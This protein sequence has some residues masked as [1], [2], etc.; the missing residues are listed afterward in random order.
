M[1]IYLYIK[2]CSHCELKYF[3]K[4]Q[5]PNPYDYKGSGKYWLEHLKKHKAKFLTLNVYFFEDQK[6][7]TAFALRFSEYNCIVESS[8]WA[9]LK[10]ENARDGG[11]EFLSLA[12]R[13]KISKAIKG[14]LVS[15]D[16]KKRISENHACVS[17]ENNPMYK[18]RHKIESIEKMK[19][20]RRTQFGETNPFYGKKHSEETKRKIS[21]TKKRNVL[22]KNST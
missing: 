18:K 2:Q 19:L 10:Y 3:G 7:A 11:A 21:E 6:E 1:S 22:L 5:N 20:N 13:Q 16:T 9:N 12:S 8:L 17:G 14:K 4:T 15:E